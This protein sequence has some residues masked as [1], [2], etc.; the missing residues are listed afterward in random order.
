VDDVIGW[1]FF[2]NNNN[3][4]D[5]NG[6]GTSVA[7]IVAGDGTRGERTGVAPNARLMV[8]KKN[9]GSD[10][11]AMERE[12]WRGIQ[13]AV[14]N[15]AHIINFSG[16][17]MDHDAPAYNTWRSAV[18][19]VM[20][21]GVLFVTG[22]G[23]VGRSTDPPYSVLTP[24]RVPVALTIGRSAND[25]SVWT[26]G[27]RG[28]VTWQTNA[29]FLD[30]PF[31]PGLVKPDLVAPGEA[32]LSTRF[33]DGS[34]KLYDVQSGSSMAAPHAAGVAA[35][36]LALHP[37]LGPYD[38]RYLME[39]S[40]VVVTDGAR[41]N[42]T[43][44]WGRLDATAAIQLAAGFLASPQ[45][46]FDLEAR[47]ISAVDSGAFKLLS[48]VVTNLGGGVVGNT[49]LCFYFADAESAVA[50]DLPSDGASSPTGASFA[51]I[52]S[53]SVSVLGPQGSGHAS[54]TGYVRWT[55]PA[56]RQHHWWI[57][58]RAVPGATAGTEGNMANNAAVIQLPDPG[59]N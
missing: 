39:E 7:G 54:A 15:G 3:P 23:N 6:H 20:D 34:G 48:A 31:T 59:G 56:T 2:D 46:G 10:V 1:N 52:G 50:G 19:N 12:C 25:D 38:L 53:W 14:E 55:P 35:L 43:S 27:C 51:K 33:G 47:E 9:S 16:G 4:A 42:F 40:S 22:A 58:V 28:P 41:P 32:V 44:G 29:P 49:E 30:Y 36:L 18:Q 37:S 45:P 24:G 5:M 13:Y 17:W 8:L 11:K 21:A 26:V 57:G